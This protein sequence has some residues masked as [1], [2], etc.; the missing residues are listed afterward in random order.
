MIKIFAGIIFLFMS[1]IVLPQ[2]IDSL[3]NACINY[4]NLQ[5]KNHIQIADKNNIDNKC[6]FGIVSDVKINFDKFSKKQQSVLA[7]VLSRP[8]LNQSIVSPAGIF[9]IHYSDTGIDSLEYSIEEFAKS[10]DSAYF[11]ETGTLG[12]PPAPADNNEGGD[13]LYD[14]YIYNLGIVYGFTTPETELGNKRYT[15]FISL[16]NS[17][18][19]SAFFTHGLDAAKV[20]IAHE[21]HHAIQI[22]NYK[23]D[24]EDIFYY[25]LTS[26]SMED[27]VF[28][29]VNDYYSYIHRYFNNTEITFAQTQG[30]GY[31]LAIWNLYLNQRFASISD[32]LGFH[33]IKRSWELIRTQRALSALSNALE[34]AGYSFKSELNNFGIWNYFTGNR[35]NP[36]YYKDGS[37]YPVV[38]KFSQYQFSQPSVEEKISVEPMTNNYLFFIDQTQGVSDTLV[39]VITDGDVQ[40]G[41]IETNSAPVKTS[42]NYL[43]SSSQSS[44]TS[45]IIKNKY[46]SKITSTEPDIFTESN[47][48]NN[49]LASAAT[50]ENRELDFVYPS[51]FRYSKNSFMRIPVAPN[52]NNSA[53]LSVFDASMNNVYY[54][55]VPIFTAGKIAVHWNG[56]DNKGSKLPTGV[57]IYVTD[58]QD[59]IKKGKIIIIN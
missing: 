28:D 34:E 42:L 24:P 51:P 18:T 25:E 10:A 59:E 54:S 43:L 30:G 13:D 14:I 7:S 33:I 26:T 8:Q 56:L 57:Y 45:V 37:V 6:A 20:T 48:F 16:D 46:Y 58:S 39:S 11:F 17:F 49:E 3:Y 52:L 36:D 19:G 50:I 29:Y 31:D 32:T 5:P 22:G 23:Y 4:F 35:Y 2:N 15:S 12:Y 41:I 1:N 21:Y 40:A 44:G 38:Q 53:V 55:T 47:F 9:R 27:F